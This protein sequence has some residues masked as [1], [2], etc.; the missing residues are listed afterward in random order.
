MA[1]P[2]LRFAHSFWI[3]LFAAGSRALAQVP[4]AGPDQELVFPSPA[5]LA[6]S[7]HGGTPLDWWCADGNGAIENDVLEYDDATGVTAVGPLRIANGGLFGSPTGFVRVGATVYGVDSLRRQ[8]YTLDPATGIVSPI[9][10][11]W[12]STYADVESLAYD[13]TGDRLFAVDRTTCQLLRIDRSNNGLTPIGNRTLGLY[14]QVYSLAWRAAT[15]SLYAVDQATRA[16]L[17]ID[18]ST[19]APTRVASV[20]LV[21]HGRIEE[22]GFVGDRL[23]GL[24]AIDDGVGLVAAQLQ[25]ISTTQGYALD[26]GPVIPQTSGLA[27]LV[28]SRPEDHVWAQVSGPGTAAFSKPYELDSVVT[29]STPGTYVLKLTVVTSGGPV[30][31]TVTVVEDA[32]PSALRMLPAGDFD[33][34]G[35]ASGPFGPHGASYVL[36]NTGGAPITWTAEVRDPWLTVAPAG[37]Q[38]GPGATVAVAAAVVDAA[39]SLL[40]VGH[41]RS[42]VQ[43]RDVSSGIVLQSRT[44]DLEILPRASA[45]DWT[46]W[47]PSVDTRVTYVSSSFGN[48]ANDGS[49][50]TKAKRTIAAGKALLRNGFPDWLLLKKGD[51]W[52]E[53][54]G[55]WSLSGRSPT[56]RMLVGSYG[57]GAQRPLIRTG[58]RSGL[59]L[60]DNGI[61][62]ND[63]A[64]IGLHFW[65]NG[66]NGGNG[67][68]RGIQVY[69]SAHD[70]LIE[71]CCVEA[72]DTNI[73]LQGSP[74]GV[75]RHANLALRRN[76]IVD[77]YTTGT[78]NTAGLF[79]SSTD[80]L[81]VEENVID[82]NGW[83]DDVPGSVPTW[84]RRNVYIQNGNTG[85][86]FRKNIVAGTDGL[87]MRPGGVVEDNL[88][89]HNAIAIMF[90][91]GTNPEPQGVSGVVRRN[92]ILDGRDLQPGS[93]RGWGLWLLNITSATIDSN[94]IAHNVS[95]HAPYPI[96]F[97]SANGWMGNFR[98]VEHTGLW[99]N[100]VHAW[101]GYSRFVGSAAQTIDV[102]LIGDRF[103]NE[104]TLDPL[105][106]HDQAGSTSGVASAINA[107]DALAAPGAWM[108]RGGLPLSLAQW[109]GLV[110]D[111]TSQASAVAFPDPTRTIATYQLSIGGLP[112]LDAF[113]AQARMQSRGYWRTQFT[114]DAVNAYIRAGYGL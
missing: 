96:T 86:V 80:G 42:V 68:P 93:A 45:A 6:G 92:V 113:L 38:L 1:A 7:V 19:G 46:P 103:Q 53:P 90:G 25:R 22:L 88:F 95:G 4:D 2:L 29:F 28:N 87:Q 94:V 105:L 78:G 36:T 57:A 77:A 13:P 110:G 61:P 74:E 108:F 16:L 33:P 8:I 101:N 84:F 5:I 14:P 10:T 100:V 73:V 37:G 52:D 111:S 109:K 15:G 43:F 40:T 59:D 44:A 24:L 64:F 23:Y 72:F 9:G 83:R 12:S 85:V 79:A 81:L 21:P 98:G 69:G 75:G 48:D 91:G 51:V 97:D 60:F 112:T 55:T 67:T 99:N 54:F 89:L 56:E 11:A 39:A 106:Q 62:H 82:H 50:T 58:S 76:V 26:V 70:L 104:I 18:P 3:A 27:M 20:A 30:I 71:D 63:L 41:H 34:R 66:F 107:F 31:D 17:A 102:E 49:S 47:T 114:A 65:A 32:G 35:I